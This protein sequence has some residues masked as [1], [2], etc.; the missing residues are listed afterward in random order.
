MDVPR[1]FFTSGPWPGW[2]LALFS[3]SSYGCFLGSVFLEA[4]V[5]PLSSFL[6]LLVCFETDLAL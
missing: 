6:F 2:F 4:E 1:L 5:F 3:E